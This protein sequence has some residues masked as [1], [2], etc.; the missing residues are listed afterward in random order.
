M[1]NESI[2][3]EIQNVALVWPWYVNA[4]IMILVLI[5]SFYFLTCAAD[6]C[7]SALN[8]IQDYEDKKRLAKWQGQGTE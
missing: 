8:K 2:S 5:F 7:A 3:I 4:A 1:P 6:M